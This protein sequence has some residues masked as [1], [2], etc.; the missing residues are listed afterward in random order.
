MIAKVVYWSITDGRYCLILVPTACRAAILEIEVG[1][2]RGIF[3]WRAIWV[4]YTSKD[5]HLG[6]ARALRLAVN[7]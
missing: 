3:S 7:T 6:P 2:Q 5:T 4:M 1:M